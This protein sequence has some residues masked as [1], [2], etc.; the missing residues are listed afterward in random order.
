MSDEVLDNLLQRSEILKEI[1]AMANSMGNND[2]AGSMSAVCNLLTYLGNARSMHYV[3]L[4]M[5]GSPAHLYFTH[6]YRSDAGDI[7]QADKFY[8]KAADKRDACKQLL[9]HIV[10]T[11]LGN[12]NSMSD[13]VLDNLL[14][15]SEILKEIYALCNG[16]QH[17]KQ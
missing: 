5:M 2:R 17:E 11:T 14:Q 9:A 15:R 13:E 8:K 16:Q 3:L 1:Y 4:V 6:F 7:D 12:D 10:K